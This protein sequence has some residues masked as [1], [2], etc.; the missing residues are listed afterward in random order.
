MVQDGLDDGPES[1]QQHPVRAGGRA[2]ERYYR[3]GARFSRFALGSA[4]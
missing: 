2:G 1:L 3:A 4:L